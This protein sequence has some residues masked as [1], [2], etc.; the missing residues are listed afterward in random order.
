MSCRLVL[1]FSISHDNLSTSVTSPVLSG[2]SFG[3]VSC[4]E[5]LALIPS[6]SA[7]IIIGWR[8]H[9]YLSVYG[10]V[11]KIDAAISILTAPIVGVLSAA[12]FLGDSVTW[13]KGVALTAIVV[14]IGLA[15]IKPRLQ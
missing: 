4:I 8:L 15:I 7:I 5:E 6:F 3:H 1:S 12:L 10:N 14:S 13:Q 9:E 2:S 11:N